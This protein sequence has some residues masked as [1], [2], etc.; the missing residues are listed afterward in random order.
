MDAT[1]ETVSHDC[2][3]RFFPLRVLFFLNIYDLKRN[4]GGGKQCALLLLKAVSFEIKCTRIIH[5]F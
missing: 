4:V 3:L 1:S 2:S 5:G